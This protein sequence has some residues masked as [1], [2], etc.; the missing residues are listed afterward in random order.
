MAGMLW[1]E[2]RWKLLPALSDSRCTSPDKVVS[3]VTRLHTLRFHVDSKRRIG[4]TLKAFLGRHISSRMFRIRCSHS[5]SDRRRCPT[6]KRSSFPVTAGQGEVGRKVLSGN[7]CSNYVCR[8]TN[9]RVGCR[10]SQQL[11]WFS[12]STQ[13]R[14]YIYFLGSVNLRIPNEHLP[15]SLLEGWS[16]AL[17]CNQR[18]EIREQMECRQIS[19][20]KERAFF[21]AASQECFG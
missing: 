2:R 1:C 9:N 16:E 10:R 8:P 4:D 13:T 14:N 21:R 19:T 3:A 6:S 18:N 20:G 5:S 17:G 15:P 11:R 7:S 12:L